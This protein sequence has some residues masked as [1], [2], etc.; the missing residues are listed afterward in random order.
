M[1]TFLMVVLALL[2]VV[3]VLSRRRELTV[4]LLLVVSLAPGLGATD[5]EA[6]DSPR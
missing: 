1:S 3:V 2:P 5:T 6:A 4:Q